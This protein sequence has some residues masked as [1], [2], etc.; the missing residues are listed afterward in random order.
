MVL[1][2]K[3]QLF[4]TSLWPNG[5]SPS[6]PRFAARHEKSILRGRII[7]PL[8]TETRETWESRD[9]REGHQGDQGDLGEQGDSTE[10]GGLGRVYGLL[11]KPSRVVHVDMA[12]TSPAGARPLTLPAG[13]R[14][15]CWRRAAP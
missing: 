6:D 7:S 1:G 12:L 11:V 9:T 2:N 3:S 4:D 14:M 8:R 13:K 5:W 15:V 10:A